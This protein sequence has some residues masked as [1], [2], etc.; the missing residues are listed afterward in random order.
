M[1]ILLVEDNPGD[2]RYLEEIL[3]KGSAA[4][5]EMDTAGSLAEAHQ[6]LSQKKYDI[7]LLDLSLPDGHG[8]ES[9]LSVRNAYPSVPIIVL[10]GLD[11]EFI[12]TYTVREGAQD[13]IVKGSFDTNL[14]LR[15][16]KYAIERKRLEHRLRAAVEKAEEA[17]VAKTNFLANMSH[18]L[19]TPLNAILGFSEILKMQLFGPL[20]DQRYQEYVND[21]YTSGQY[22][23]SL[24]S[25]LLD[26]S[27]AKAGKLEL[28]ETTV[29]LQEVL[30]DC[31][32]LV[33]VNLEKKE[34]TLELFLEEIFLWADLRLIKQITLNL[35]S[36]AIKFTPSKGHVILKT[37]NK[38]GS[39]YFGFKVKDTGKGIDS[40]D[41]GK[42]LEPFTQLSSSAEALQ[43]GTG[44]GLT[45]TKHM[46]ELHGGHVSIES[47]LS[48]GTEVTIDFPRWRG[49]IPLKTFSQVP[50][51]SEKIEQ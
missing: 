5:L 20:G 15:M 11:D 29:N 30:K 17:N 32:N 25:D 45:L 40:K 4:L 6:L 1:K 19:R 31:A 42:V 9:L 44:L 47:E 51:G 37:F 14:I 50:P 3:I 35:L 36:N 18:E 23:L 7:V 12:S 26:L 41:I 38:P 28:N 21:I 27:K 16:M 2:I 10:T 49:K 46:I 13:Y 22:L 8:I 48:K 39:N 34:I 33:R 43:T 24:I